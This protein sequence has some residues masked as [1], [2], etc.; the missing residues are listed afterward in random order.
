MRISDW[1][2]DVC[3]SDLHRD[4]IGSEQAILG[5]SGL[6]RTPMCRADHD[7][8]SLGDQA[9]WSTPRTAG[10]SI[11]VPKLALDAPIAGGGRLRDNAGEGIG[12]ASCWVGGCPC[13]YMSVVAGTHKKNKHNKIRN[14]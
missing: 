8:A 10:S 6:P 3:S 13:V 11:A 7:A 4:D 1:S 14:R 5:L 12:R 9:C 2:S